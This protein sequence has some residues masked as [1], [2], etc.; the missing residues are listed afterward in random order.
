MNSSDTIEK[1]A[2]MMHG[3]EIVPVDTVDDVVAVI[4]KCAFDAIDSQRPSMMGAL[5]EF[6]YD[7]PR[8][9]SEALAQINAFVEE[10]TVRSAARVKVDLVRMAWPIPTTVSPF[11]EGMEDLYNTFV[12]EFKVCVIAAR[13]GERSEQ[14]SE[15][16]DEQGG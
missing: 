10:L 3:H 13:K 16:R 15:Q 5:A 1:L 11:K 4:G 12:E 8:A 6:F 2:A 9:E 14:R 7:K